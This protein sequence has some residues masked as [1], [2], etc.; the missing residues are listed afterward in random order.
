MDSHADRR[1]EAV[2]D[3]EIEVARRLAATLS[4]EREALTGSS[5]GAVGKHAEEKVALFGSFEQLERERRALW[6][7]FGEPAAVPVATRWQ[8]LMQIMVQCRNANEIN[9]YII[10]LRRVQVRQLI[11][12]L[13]GGPALTYGPAG[14]TGPRA[15]R[16]LA[17]A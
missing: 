14:K 12:V 1:L 7:S 13:R 5:P 11:D 9:G 16:A 10:N 6:E 8:A 2:L 4:A 15:L 17:R 3:R